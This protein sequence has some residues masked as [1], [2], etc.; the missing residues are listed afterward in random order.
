MKYIIGL[1]VLL[2]V[3]VGIGYFIKKRYYKEMDRLESWKMDLK[4][5]PVLDEMTKVKQLNMNGQ[6]EELFENWRNQWDDIVTVKLPG[7]EDLLF[8]AEDFIDHYRFRKAKLTQ[9]GIEK[10]L[11]DIEA[12]ISR[13]LEELNELIGSEE[14]NRA[15]IGQLKDIYREAKKNLL[16]HSHIYGQAESVLED[17]LDEVIKKFQVYDEKTANGNYLEAREIVLFMQDHLEKIK[18]QMDVIP[19]LLSECKSFIPA[20]L[21]DLRDGYREMV[22]QGYFLDHIQMENEISDLEQ[23]LSQSIRDIEVTDIDKAEESVKEIRDRVD[24]LF[25]LLEKE[26]HAKH[27]VVL[28]EK[29][30][31]DLLHQLQT[32]NEKVNDEVIEVQQSYQIKED[33][34]DMQRKFDQE[35]TTMNKRF[36]FLSGKIANHEAAQTELSGELKEIKDQL[37]DFKTKQQAFLTKLQDLRKDEMEA[38]EK[39]QELSKQ[40]REAIRELSKTNI[41]GLPE[42]YQYL[43]K[44]GKESIENVKR[45]LKQKPLDISTL[46]QYLEVAVLTIEKLVTSTNELMENADLAEK[47]IQYGNRYRSKYSAVAKALTEAETSFRHFEYKSA[48]EQAATSIQAVDPGAIKKIETLLAREINP[49]KE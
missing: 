12:D 14:K 16:A 34:L 35:L 44:D 47:V 27:F 46:K 15:E 23:A 39:I 9:Q 33:T 41:P 7:L 29:E 3:M 49:N 11:L 13:I 1:L 21:S 6:T 32:E 24:I 38:R 25:D 43:F 40:V 19:Q 36:E 22:Q 4:N 37:D 18:H 48:L 42:D 26:V 10:Q 8:D 2:L 20:Q 31:E 30:T 5:R 45:Q 28:H 17:E